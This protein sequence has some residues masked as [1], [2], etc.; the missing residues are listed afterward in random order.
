M[1]FKTHKSCLK[2]YALGCDDL[3]RNYCKLGITIIALKPLGPCYKPTNNLT[4]AIVKC[5]A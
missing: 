5:V 3:N 2:C 4:Y 1:K